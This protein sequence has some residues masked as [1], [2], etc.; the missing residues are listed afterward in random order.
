MDFLVNSKKIIILL[1]S[2]DVN[3][4]NQDIFGKG[5]KSR[6]T[7]KYFEQYFECYKVFFILSKN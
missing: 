2:R 6:F 4:I 7:K 5:R 1:K 3:A